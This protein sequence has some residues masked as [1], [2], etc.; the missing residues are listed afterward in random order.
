MRLWTSLWTSSARVRP[1][2]VADEPALNAGLSAPEPVCQRLEG[3][4]M[5][6]RE[7][8]EVREELCRSRA[9]HGEA[10][11]DR[12]SAQRVDPVG[13]GLGRGG[14][15]AER[16]DREPVRRP[17]LLRRLEENEPGSKGDAQEGFRGEP[18]R[19]SV[20]KRLDEAHRAGQLFRSVTLILTLT[21]TLTL[22]PT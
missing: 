19:V 5:E 12:A 9:E 2:P 4:A 6:Q 18:G 7:R 21:L 10:R 8:D 14:E 1:S 3:A 20:R 13:L 22:T 17:S 15:E 11:G 16:D